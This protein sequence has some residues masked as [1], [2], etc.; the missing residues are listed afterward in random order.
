LAKKLQKLPDLTNATA[1]AKI[2][3]LALNATNPEVKEA[4]QLMIKGGTPSPS[5]FRYTV[6][7]YN[8]ELQVLYWLACQNEFK[9]DDTLALSIAMVNGFWVTVGDERV[10][11]A[12]YND[13]TQLLRYFRETNEIQKASGYP[14]LEEYPLEAKVCLVWT[15]NITPN[16]SAFP[17]LWGHGEANTRVLGYLYN[18]TRLDSFGYEWNTVSVKTLISMRE[19][20]IARDWSKGDYSATVERLERFFYLDP[21]SH[22]KSGHSAEWGPLVYIGLGGKVVRDY[23][24]GNM[25]AMYEYY[26]THGVGIGTCNDESAW[27]DAWAKSMGIATTIV[28]V[29]DFD[30]QVHHFLPIWFDPGSRTWKATHEQFVVN[31]QPAGSLPLHFM[32]FQP[33]VNLV[34]YFNARE[35]WLIG[36]S[37]NM[38]YWYSP[39]IT[40]EDIEEMLD[41]G[42]ST[43]QMKQWLLYS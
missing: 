30:G 17:V 19:E 13:T 41:S 16:F 42:T 8:T 28:W 20:A 40:L 39:L 37:P 33:P 34:R 27:T 26:S 10:R 3:Y 36:N 29:G 6:P 25:N 21:N 32:F 35:Q 31:V 12:V 4:F 7:K 5:D 9:R 38:F 18:H 43:S 23:I 2:V 22:W 24:I 11:Q 1:V 14:E 15:G